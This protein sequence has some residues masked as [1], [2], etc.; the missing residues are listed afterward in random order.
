MRKLILRN[1]E[2]LEINIENYK[3]IKNLS[4]RSEENE[5]NSKMDS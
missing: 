3:I 2:Y 4:G 1:I 5:S